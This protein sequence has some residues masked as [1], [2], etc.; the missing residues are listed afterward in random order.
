[1]NYK[2]I[3]RIENA[4]YREENREMLNRKQRERYAS[5]SEYREYQRIYQREYWKMYE[6]ASRAA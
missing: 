3:K 5:N 1:M 2:E 6:R 4:I